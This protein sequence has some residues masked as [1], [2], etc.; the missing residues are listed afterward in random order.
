M[1]MHLLGFEKVTWF[2]SVCNWHLA[3]YMLFVLKFFVFVAG[4]RQP[5]WPCDP[6]RVLVGHIPANNEIISYGS[7]Y[8]GNSL[9]GKKCFALRIASCLAKKEGWFAEHMLVNPLSYLL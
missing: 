5:Q 3:K 9:L 7:G 4:V 8:G 6:A 2:S 1:T